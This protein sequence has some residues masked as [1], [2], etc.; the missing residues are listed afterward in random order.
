MMHS[1]SRPHL[2][3]ADAHAFEPD[4]G[5]VVAT[6]IE[7]SAPTVANGLRQ[8]ELVKTGHWDRYAEDFAL[9]ADFGIRYLRYGIPFHVVAR[10]PR[11]FDWRWTDAALRSLRA[12]GLEPIVDLLH[13]GVTDDLAGMG[14][15]RLVERYSRYAAAF[16]ERYPWVRYY[17]PVN[18]PLLASVMSAGLG[19]WNE[20]A[21]D[22]R[23]LTATIVNLARCAV[24]GMEI[25]RER[26]PD[27]VFIQSEPCEVYIP[28][29]PAAQPGVDFLNERRFVAFDLT[30]GRRPA[31]A[32]VGWLAKYDIGEDTLDWFTD[33][34]STENCILGH[35]YYKGNEWVVAPDGATT[36]AARDDERLGYAALAR[37]YHDRYGMP[38]MLS[39]TNTAGR[40]APGW[41]VE[42]WNDAL[43]LREEGLPIRGYCW[44][45]FVDHV[46]WDSGLRRNLGRA[47]PCGL[48]DLDRRAHPVGETYRLLATAARNGTLEP[49]PVPRRRRK[50]EKAA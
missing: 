11:R 33:H 12:A 25:L 15:P 7:C 2:V 26:R 38:F 13:F 50:A 35:D 1:T 4:T 27:A 6:G 49:L 3:P 24:V 39:E 14:D 10:D 19:W 31:D 20:R 46:D 34:G 32:V 42:T 37:Q 44:Y 47:N 36:R 41:L 43:E 9:V 5:F 8:D 29:E 28:S 22:Q 16:A 40:R 45:G 21:R 48:V 18:E 17:T 23:A 30:Y